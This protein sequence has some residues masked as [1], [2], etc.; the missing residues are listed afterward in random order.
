MYINF[1]AMQR[2]ERGEVD[3]STTAATLELAGMLDRVL[4]DYDLATI[5]RATQ[6][7]EQHKLPYADNHKAAATW[8]LDVVREGKI[9]KASGSPDRRWNL[10]NHYAAA[11]FVG[12]LNQLRS[13]A[14]STL[15]DN[16]EGR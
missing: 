2:L 6:M 5:K 12:C 9:D 4:N 3:S 16:I 13:G 14:L 8:L 11:S 15:L 7:L 1:P 10:L